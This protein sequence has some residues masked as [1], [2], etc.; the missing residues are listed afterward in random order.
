M[1]Q[2][3]GFATLR[4]RAKE[5]QKLFARQLPGPAACGFPPAG[6]RCATRQG[7]LCRRAAG[8]RNPGRAAHLPQP[9][10]ERKLGRRPAARTCRRGR[11]ART[12][13]RGLAGAGGARG[14]AGAGLPARATAGGGF[15]GAPGLS[16]KEPAEPHYRTAAVRARRGGAIAAQLL[17]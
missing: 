3:V 10:A 2:Q 1:A 17:D 11:R 7:E 8:A 5:F 15:T 6:A 13:R 16:K 9:L 14:L 4:R 12:C